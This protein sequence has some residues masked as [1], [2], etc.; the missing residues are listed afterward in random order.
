MQVG[1]GDGSVGP[2][3][4]S[5]GMLLVVLNELEKAHHRATMFQATT[6]G[7]VAASARLDEVE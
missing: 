1:L 2:D 6:V 3:G 5:Q 4:I 7:G